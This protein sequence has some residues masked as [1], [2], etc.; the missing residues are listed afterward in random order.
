MSLEKHPIGILGGTFDPVHNGHL[1]M[2]KHAQEQLN[3]QLVEFIPNQSPPHREQPRASAAHRLAMLQMATHDYPNFIV[4]NIELNRGKGPSYSYKT[5][6]QIRKTIPSQPICFIIGKDVLMTFN[7]WHRWEEILKLVHLVVVA[8]HHR[9]PDIPTWLNN[10]L[11]E[12]LTHDSRDLSTEVAGKIYCCDI[13]PI[14][15]SASEIR[16]RIKAHEDISQLVPLS[17]ANYIQQHHLYV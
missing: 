6:L 4:N 17:V 10:W 13:E 2:A 8:R 5:L 14:D 3:L 7:T 1:Q 15:V 12:H 16:R 11:D 9:T